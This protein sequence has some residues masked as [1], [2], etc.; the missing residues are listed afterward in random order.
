MLKY[1]RIRGYSLTTVVFVAAVILLASK[2]ANGASPDYD[3]VLNEANSQLKAHETQVPA[4]NNAIDH[5]INNTMYLC[6]TLFDIGL[7]SKYSILC[8]KEMVMLDKVCRVNYYT[9]C[10]GQA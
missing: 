6:A 3:K 1:R 8:D 5:S 7:D 2:Y 10:F 4:I 9:F